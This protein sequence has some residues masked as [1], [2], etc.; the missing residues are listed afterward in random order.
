MSVCDECFGTGCNLCEEPL[1]PINAGEIAHRVRSC[2]SK[3]SYPRETDAR[4]VI[5]RREKAGRIMLK[6]YPCKYCNGWH[7]SKRIR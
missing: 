6:A 4:M 1:E 7:I 5:Q 3:K 2:E